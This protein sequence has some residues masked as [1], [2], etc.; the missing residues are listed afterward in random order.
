MVREALL[1]AVADAIQD[2]PACPEPRGRAAGRRDSVRRPGVSG[3]RH[4]WGARRNVPP[5]PGRNPRPIRGR[6][7]AAAAG[8]SIGLGTVLLPLKPRV[9]RRQTCGACYR[10]SL[11]TEY[12]K[13][14]W[15]SET[16][17]TSAPLKQ[18]P[19]RAGPR[20]HSFAHRRGSERQA[21][22]ET[23]GG[24]N[25][26]SELL[27]AGVP[28]VGHT[29]TPGV[30]L[31]HVVEQSFANPPLTSIFVASYKCIAIDGSKNGLCVSKRTRQRVLMINSRLS[32][33]ALSRDPCSCLASCRAVVF[34]VNFPIV[35]R[36][37][38]QRI[39]DLAA[40]PGR[41]TRLS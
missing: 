18:N 32:A 40:L 37:I 39:S 7:C 3:E 21:S 13:P 11:L 8:D 35:R 36:P 16:F 19:W 34:G 31:V 6:K 38:Y 12:S 14:W 28:P 2:N 10:A 30:L 4:G 41:R 23:T 33:H 22:G 1:D 15:C 27:A 24:G 25:Q 20:R 17:A 29:Y 5:I 9:G 26:L